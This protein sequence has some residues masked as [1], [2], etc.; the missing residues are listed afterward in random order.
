MARKPEDPAARFERMVDRTG[1]HHLWLGST[2]QSG[3]GRFKLN[4][5]VDV[6]AH[7]AAWELAHGP[8]PARA[9]VLACPS[10]PACVRTEHL[11]LEGEQTQAPLPRARARKGAGSI[12]RI[13]PGS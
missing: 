10:D 11:R 4:S 9:R 7:H 13:R 1:Q 12:R 5:K 8:L 2:S 3:A 6:T